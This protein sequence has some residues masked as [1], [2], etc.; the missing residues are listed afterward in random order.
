M[1]NLYRRL[2]WNNIK[3]GKHFYLPYLLAGMISAMMYYSI[4]TM[5]GNEGLHEMRGGSILEEI[6]KFGTWVIAIFVCIFLF[7][8]NSFLMKRRRKELGIYNI[9]GMEKRHITKIMFWETLFSWFVTVAGGLLAGI[10]FNKL[11]MMFLYRL[12]GLTTSIR[13]YISWE[14]CLGTAELFGV[15]YLC[16]LFYNFLQIQLANP[17][18]L[19]RSS[20]T[21]EREPKTRVLMAAV[22]VLSLGVAYYIAITT[23]NPL[24]ALLLFFVAVVLVII[25]TYCLFTAGSIAFLKL[26]RKNKKYYYQTRH[27]TTVSG[28]LYRMKQNAAGLANICI[29]STMVL[30]MISTTVSMYVGLEDELETRY[31]AEMEIYFY[32]GTIPTWEEVTETGSRLSG[33]A[34]DTGRVVL[35]EDAARYAGIAGVWKDDQ[36]LFS[37]GEVSSEWAA[38][39]LMT[40]QDYTAYTGQ[41]TGELSG[42]ELAV[43]S[44]QG[45]EGDYLRVGETEYTVAE[46]LDF[47]DGEEDETVDHTLFLVVRDD[48]VFTDILGAANEAA[49]AQ[50]R[51]PIEV[52]TQINVDVDGTAEEKLACA[53]ALRER[54]EVWKNDGTLPEVLR[55]ETMVRFRQE[56]YQNFVAVNGGLFFLGLFLGSMFLMITVLIIYYKQISEGYD[57]KERF[58]IMEK[59]GMSNAEVKTAIRSQVCTVFFLPLVTA[60]IHLAAAYPMLKN[61]LALLAL[62]NGTLFLWCM[63]GTVLVFGLIY[64]IVFVLTSRSY[65][66]I[67]GNQV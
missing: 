28:M 60:V 10:I 67:V 49:A 8:T 4:R 44:N 48:A 47:P 66:K 51:L 38:V 52:T 39:Y 24:Q 61:L 23:E 40:R 29:L 22:G 16:I 12:T 20:N 11:L 46:L 42:Q 34:K 9:L 56:G 64:L 50:G 37:S 45:F 5:Q 6:L 54:V 19:L 33:A 57:D 27:F 31:R 13:F 2:A 43:A 41:E 3:N 26:L 59:V 36:I 18:E 15:L 17:I 35:G 58:A 25:G 55:G 62:T 63:A 1:N 53:Q 30:V 14:N 7:Y 21:G 32:S 65:Y